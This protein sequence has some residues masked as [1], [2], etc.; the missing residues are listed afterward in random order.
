MERWLNDGVDWSCRDIN[1][2]KN[3]VCL[4][5]SMRC[6]NLGGDDIAY[7]SGVARIDISNEAS[8]QVGTNEIRVVF[9]KI[10]DGRIRV[11]WH[12][13]TT[14]FV[15]LGVANDERIH[16]IVKTANQ[17]VRDSNMMQI[18]VYRGDT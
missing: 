17:S 14:A 16:Q 18:R 13:D 15:P 11:I 10:V 7:F 4:V 1:E 9:Q 12:N 3:K 8:S 6:L 2:F 5:R